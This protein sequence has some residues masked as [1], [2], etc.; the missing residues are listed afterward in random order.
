MDFF[1]IAIICTLGGYLWGRHDGSKNGQV[2]GMRSGL[3][4]SIHYVGIS[5][6]NL[7]F[8]K[9]LNEEHKK[10]ISTDLTHFVERHAHA[11]LFDQK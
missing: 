3:S 4:W 10:Q 8:F 7:D 2:A 5:I 11:K 1:G 9:S 6:W